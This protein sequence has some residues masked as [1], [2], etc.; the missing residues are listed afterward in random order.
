MPPVGPQSGRRESNTV[1][2]TKL[3][4]LW[5]HE[6]AICRHVTLVARLSSKFHGVAPDLWGRS[7]VIVYHLICAIAPLWPCPQLRR[8]S[9]R[10]VHADRVHEPPLCVQR[11][12]ARLPAGDPARR[13]VT[14]V[15]TGVLCF[16][17]A[18]KMDGVW[19]LDIFLAT[20][21]PL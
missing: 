21:S 15:H 6:P 5:T 3:G 9:A 12:P 2:A 10:P 17:E 8:P 4:N 1:Q 16:C 11:R 20:F 7:I 13:Q 14:A 18:I 19:F